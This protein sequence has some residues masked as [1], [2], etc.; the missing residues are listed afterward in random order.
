MGKRF[1]TITRGEWEV[2]AA[3]EIPDVRG[4]CPCAA[5]WL[6]GMQQQ[7]DQAGPGRPITLAV[8]DRFLGTLDVVPVMGAFPDKPRD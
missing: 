4:L 3:R 1:V 7:F 2:L 8:P 5:V 6:E